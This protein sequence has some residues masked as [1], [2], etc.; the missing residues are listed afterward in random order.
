M[1]FIERS[2][3]DED[4]RESEERLQL[5]VEYAPIAIAMFDRHM[6]YLVA[7]RRWLTDYGLE[8]QD[9]VG[10]SHYEIF[11][12]VPARWRDIHGRC[13]GGIEAAGEDPFD[14]DGSRQWLRWE[15]RPWKRTNGELGGIVIF[16]EDI[17][18][19]K[20]MEQEREELFKRLKKSQQDLASKV[21][22]LELFHDVAVGREF[23]LMQ[24]EREVGHLR[25]ALA[26]L[27]QK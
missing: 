3:A 20:R 14:L 10:R 11:P 16:T 26:E 6:R 9:I 18:E 27:R 12:E 24:L 22:D 21:A 7:S 1:D 17:T 15:I 25:S 19:R 5:F 8:G 2:R 23:K 4:L 13:L